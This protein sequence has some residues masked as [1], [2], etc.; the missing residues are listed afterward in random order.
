[1]AH[2]GKS[3]VVHGNQL[4]KETS[5]Y[6]LQ[7]KDN[8][9]HWWAWGPTAFD[10]A[11]QRNQP[12]LLSVGYAACHWCHVMAHES[13]EDGATAAIMNAHFI[14]IKLDREERPDLDMIYQAALALLGQQG[15]WPLTMFLT[16]DGEPF[17][18]G[19]YFPR[20]SRYG[21]P[22][23]TDILLRISTL[24]RDERMRVLENVTAMREALSRL[25][26]SQGDLD[27]ERPL[28]IQSVTPERL[29]EIARSIL[30]DVDPEEGGF[31]APPKFPHVPDLLFLWQ[32][33]QRTGARD[34]ENAVLLTLRKMAQGGIY[35]HLGGGFSRYS[36]DRS[37]LV[38]HFEK[39]LYDNAQLLE[40]LTLAAIEKGDDL[41]TRRIYET[42][43]WLAEDMRSEADAAGQRAFIA[44][45]DADSEGE[46]GK[47][48][49]WSEREIDTELGSA[50]ALFKTYYHVTADGNWEGKN[51]L[52]RSPDMGLAELEVESRLQ[53]ACAQLLAARK[54]RTPPGR[55]D[56]VLADWNGLAIAAL[57]E[58]GL[59]F[60]EPSWCELA[61]EAYAFVTHNLQA[62]DGRLYHSWRAGQARHPAI[63]EDYAAMA[64]AALRLYEWESVRKGDVAEQYRSDAE[65][66]VD[67][68]NAHY[69]DKEGGGYFMT[70]DDTKDVIH[71]MKPGQDHAIPSGNGMMMGVLSRLYHLTGEDA[72][73]K[74]AEALLPCFLPHALRQPFGFASV[75]SEAATHYE[76]IRI[77]IV[78]RADNPGLTDLLRRIYAIARLGRLVSRFDPGAGLPARH[79][80]AAAAQSASDLTV[81]VCHG[82]Q[83]SLPLPG[84]SGLEAELAS[85]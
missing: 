8:P 13:F 38:P 51:I 31:G 78:G 26:H 66:W 63:L 15:G 57:V 74:R 20:E 17:W 70:A 21:R 2:P 29:N 27:S 6:L 22:A 62:A 82:Q 11:K 45:I 42:V 53:R 39:M 1:M 79:P 56:K 40:I 58:A 59:A 49:V 19:T 16:P 54:I 52:T 44:A 12:I 55:D 77:V 3:A 25:S 7:H 41:L 80:A 5:P 43:H 37:W 72:Y 64:R 9:V 81:F 50:A 4:A 14:N 83:C 10:A 76:M 75:L 32:A 60:D 33:G 18:G 35:D 30:S 23:F 47:Y 85:R 73:R 65:H 46:E 36:V 69:W 67:I 48:Y 84:G 68:L 71:R 34:F 28:S 61:A 24:Y